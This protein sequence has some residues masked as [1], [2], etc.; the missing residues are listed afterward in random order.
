[1]RLTNQ[2]RLSPTRK[3]EQRSTTIVAGQGPLHLG[4]LNHQDGLS[5]S[6]G[7]LDSVS[8]IGPPIVRLVGRETY[9]LL[10]SHLNQL[11]VA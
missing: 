10:G 8:W 1:M 6:H 5:D 3:A 9:N 4:Q 11:S 2:N 7:N